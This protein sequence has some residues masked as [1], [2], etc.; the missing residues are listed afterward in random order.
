VPDG[1]AGESIPKAAR[2]LAIAVA[3]A[4]SGKAR[5]QT[6]EDIMKGSGTTFEPEAVRLFLKVTRSIELPR[7]IRECCL[8][9]LKPGMVLAKGIYSPTGLLLIPEDRTLTPDILEKVHSRNLVENV[10]DRLLVYT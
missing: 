2:L 9:D 5:E 7:K 1:W 4:E 10:N 6:V 8:S 3:Y